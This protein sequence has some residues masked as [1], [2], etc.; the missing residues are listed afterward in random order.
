MKRWII[1]ADARYA[2]ARRRYGGYR[3]REHLAAE[4]DLIGRLKFATSAPTRFDPLM[5]DWKLMDLE[6]SR[7]S[8]WRSDVAKNADPAGGRPAGS[9]GM[10]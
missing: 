8:H 6:T 4:S 2:R 1:L 5:L 7:E 9:H 10:P 3:L